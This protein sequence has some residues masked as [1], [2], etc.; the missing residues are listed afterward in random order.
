MCTFD[1]G[2]EEDQ[3]SPQHAGRELPSFYEIL[4]EHLVAANAEA[5]P[6]A[7]PQYWRDEETPLDELA[8]N[9][10]SQ[11]AVFRQLGGPALASVTLGHG[12]ADTPHATHTD[13]QGRG[14]L[15]ICDP[16][17]WGVLHQLAHLLT[18]GESPRH[19]LDTYR[20]LVLE[21]YGEFDAARFDFDTVERWAKEEHDEM[22]SES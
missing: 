19:W 7:D 6:G 2:A 18:Q 8:K 1:R 12:R 16:N 20:N 9:V 14:H 10:A 21:R 22:M 17:P 13:D 15:V 3:G 5:D 11:S 4:D